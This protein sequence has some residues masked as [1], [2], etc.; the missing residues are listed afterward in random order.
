MENDFKKLLLINIGIIV[1]IIALSFFLFK[2]FSNAI[3]QKAEE[4]KNMRNS[5]FLFNQSLSNL[6][7]L[8]EISPRVDLYK[9]KLDL[10]LPS[11]DVLID[12]P[13]WIDDAAQASQVKVNFNFKS[14][15]QN[16]DKDNPGFEVFIIDISGPLLNIEKFLFTIEKGSPQFLLS[17]DSFN[18]SQLDANNYQFSG[19]GRAFFVN[20]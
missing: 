3:N 1:L 9:N 13:R 19:S 2:Y 17:I 5:V 4:I 6:A 11:K 10:L 16:P 12:L 7:K 14:G 8:K 15:G 18:I 20:K